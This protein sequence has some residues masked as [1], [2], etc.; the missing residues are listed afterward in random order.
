MKF[1]HTA[2]FATPATMVLSL[3]SLPTLPAQAATTDAGASGTSGPEH[4]SA[5]RE[6]GEKD[7]VA[8]GSMDRLAAKHRVGRCKVAGHVT[9][10]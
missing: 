6:L 7:I 8:A 5:G 4:S 3:L 2:F 10:V 9:V 1:T